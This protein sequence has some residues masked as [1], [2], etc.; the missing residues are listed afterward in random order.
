M[1]NST[2]WS[3]KASIIGPYSSH[4]MGAGARASHNNATTSTIR[5]SS[6]AYVGSTTDITMTFTTAHHCAPDDYIIFTNADGNSLV[7]VYRVKTVTS[8]WPKS[9]QEGPEF[10]MPTN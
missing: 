5:A 4:S 8:R 9:I 2:I 3:N 7:G 10:K 6:T 1:S